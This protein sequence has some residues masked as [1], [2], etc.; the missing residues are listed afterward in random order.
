MTH[1][2][3][4]AVEHGDPEAILA[5]MDLLDRGELRVASR[6]DDTW[7]THAWINTANHG[8]FRLRKIGRAHV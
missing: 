8:C 6:I 3:K 7:E 1:P 5:A 2:L 4:H